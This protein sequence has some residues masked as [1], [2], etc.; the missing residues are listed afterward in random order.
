MDLLPKT[1]GNRPRIACEIAPG[2]VVAARSALPGG[3]LAAVSRV[4]LAEGAIAPSLKP[5]NVVDRVATIA[6]LRRALEGV[7]ARPNARNADLTLVIPDSA[8]RVL[9]LDFDAL[10]SKL[11]ES[12]PIVR[13]RLKRL[14]PFDT[15]DAMVTFQVMSSARNAIRVLAV[16]IPR[17]VLADYET[18][19]REA[20]FE[21]GAVLPSTLAALAGL[22]ESEGG[23]LAVNL[24]PSGMTTAI[25]RGG[26]LLLHRTV[27]LSD[28]LSANA[29]GLPAAQIAPGF[30]RET[31]DAAQAV[32][33]LPL[34]SRE[35]TAE[36]WAAQEPLPEF[37]RNPYADAIAAETAVEDEDATTGFP[38][39]TTSRGSGD[40]AL[41]SLFRPAAD[42]HNGAAMASV[43]RSPY[44][45]LHVSDDLQAEV[46]NSFL[47]GPPAGDNF[48]DGFLAARHGGMPKGFAEEDERSLDDLAVAAAEDDAAPVH[49]LAPDAQA[50]E[51]ARAVSVAV[52]YFED[53]LSAPPEVLWSAGPL[54][55]EKLSRTLQEQGL[56]Q[57]M[58]LRCRELVDAGSLSSEATV[59]S[60]PRSLLAGV[61]GALGS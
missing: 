52:A 4:E 5:G 33:L 54:G 25:V 17:D 55:A 18:V 37:G 20:G 24:Y 30:V 31:A 7:G 61:V 1:Q 57:Q 15:D 51:I 28:S 19:A 11:S 14:V 41:R 27:E 46:H 56:L 53:V 6:A 21:P 47:T 3:P 29:P 39:G 44:A 36:E 23:A 10:P 32:E 59:A 16:A 60:V 50:E 26:V 2:S 42:L 38:S 34:V 12:L 40:P 48:Q 8:V 49:T 9:L 22:P 35:E 13:F 45:G 43:E 58:G